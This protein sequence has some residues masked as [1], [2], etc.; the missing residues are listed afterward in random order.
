MYLPDSRRDEETQIESI[1]WEGSK[2]ESRI[3][4][5]MNASFIDAVRNCICFIFVTKL[6][7]GLLVVIV[8]V[9]VPIFHK[10]L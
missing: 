8:F 4:V 6:Q 10:K 2:R 5:C 9:I 3:L 1:L 7:S